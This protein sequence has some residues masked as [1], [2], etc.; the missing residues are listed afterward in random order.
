VNRRG[1]EDDGDDD[2]RESDQ[3]E[4]DPAE[5]ESASGHRPDRR[6]GGIRPDRPRDLLRRGRETAVDAVFPR[7]REYRSAPDTGLHE[8]RLYWRSVFPV[9][10]RPLVIAHRG[11]SGYRPEHTASAYLLAIEL[12]ADAV[13]PDL[14]PTRDG[15]L[16]VRHE[17]EISGTT[18]VAQHP[19]FADRR[20]TK[21]IDGVTHDGWFT[22]DLTWAELSTLRAR[23]RLALLRPGSAEF[24]G[25]DGILRLTDLIDILDAAGR[26]VVMVAELKHA[27]YFDSIGLPLEA[28]FAS[29]IARWGTNDNLVVESF[30]RTALDRVRKLGAPGKLTF[31]AEA[32]GTPA[33][34]LA[35][36]GTHGRSY[37]D[38]LTD[39][40]L[41]GLAQHVDGLSVDKTLLFVRDAGGEVTG[42]TDLIDR[43]HRA[44]LETFTWTLRAENLFLEQSFRRGERPDEHGD[45]ERE[46]AVILGTGVDGVFADQPDLALRARAAL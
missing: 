34:E 40:G 26:P 43:A 33:D 13:E 31:L 24:D 25:Q 3:K 32:T 22:E 7:R 35:Q 21:V 14:V 9:T 20:T 4:P 10:T 38:Y 18:D 11:A 17:N 19:E 1:D 8:V 5:Y 12:G 15:V 45:W 42:T 36:F 37:A 28:T 39:E 46:Y 44:G 29:E 23:E 27:T 2:E 30:E 6:D 16:V 41:A